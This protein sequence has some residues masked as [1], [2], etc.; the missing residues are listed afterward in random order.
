M[1]FGAESASVSVTS[2][3][4]DRI[5]GGSMNARFNSSEELREFGL[6][7]FAAAEVMENAQSEAP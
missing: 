3:T 7:C 1:V 2:R 6:R 4:E 5:S